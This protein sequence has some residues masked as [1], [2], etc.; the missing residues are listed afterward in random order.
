ME[1]FPKGAAMAPADAEEMAERIW[2]GLVARANRDIKPVFVS[3]VREML[4][5]EDPEGGED[6]ITAKD[7]ARAKAFVARFW[8]SKLAGKQPKAAKKP[9]RAKGSPSIG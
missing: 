9:K 5:D 3:L 6:G 2:R 7:R 1:T 4:S 8:M